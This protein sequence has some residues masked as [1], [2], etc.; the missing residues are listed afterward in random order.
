MAVS[1]TTPPGLT[2]SMTTIGASPTGSAPSPSIT[3][4]NRY[5]PAPTVSVAPSVNTGTGTP[6]AGAAL[7][8]EQINAQ[9]AGQ[10]AGD[11]ATGTAWANTV[12]PDGT[13]SR[14]GSDAD[15]RDYL[16]K[17]KDRTNGMTP[18][19][20][21][22]E[23]EQ[24]TANSNG[25]LATNL[26]RANQISG[27]AGVRGGAAAGLQMQA[28]NHSIDD[29]AS[30][31][32]QMVLDN[33]GQKNNAFAAYGTN[34][35][36]VKTYDAGQTDKE[37]VGRID[38]A[39]GYGG[40][41]DGARTGI[42][43]DIAAADSTQAAKD[44][45]K[46]ISDKAGGTSGP[47]S[48]P[49]RNTPQTSDTTNGIQSTVSD[50][51]TKHAKDLQGV[52]AV[53]AQFDGSADKVKGGISDYVA[54]AFPDLSDTEKTAKNAAIQKGIEVQQMLGLPID[55]ATAADM[56][57]GKGLTDEQ[58]GKVNHISMNRSVGKPDDATAVICTEAMRQGKFDRANYPTGSAR[59]IIGE[60]NMRAYHVWGS[61]AVSAMRKNVFVTDFFAWILPDTLNA[62]YSKP[63][64]FR[65][66]VGLAVFR[67]MNT[68]VKLTRP[69]LKRERA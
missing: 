61:L 27:N 51:Y 36:G 41:V 3:L 53:G 31:Q 47:A 16:S 50:I 21:R 39:T 4:P 12:M 17:L 8:P 19:E 45:L 30:L 37:K 54:N 26:A 25:V 23:Y 69:S 20:L 57:E 46:S 63:H 65:G 55:M 44:Y 18:D 1:R 11:M 14:L 40:M 59:Q 2:S 28:L 15:I 7:T 49:D 68:L 62:I 29:Q 56:G 67:S 35:M 13:L 33:I 9:A 6:A 42:K 10:V 52:G 22:A 66:D 58:K 64:R 32:R 24:G 34:L 38:L 5:V 43:A 48:T 60:S